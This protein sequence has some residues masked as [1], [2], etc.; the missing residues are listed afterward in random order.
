MNILIIGGGGREHAMAWKMARSPQLEKLFIAPGNAGTAMVGTNM[1]VSVDDF[2][3]IKELVLA[4]KIEMVVVGPEVPL[5]AGVVDFFME[6]PDLKMLNT[7]TEPDF[8]K[9]HY[10]ETPRYTRQTNEELRVQ[11]ANLFQ[12]DDERVE[13]IRQLHVGA[14]P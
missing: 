1:P 13:E 3:G 5:V 11:L 4:E 10:K 7:L 9:L 6:D 14:T 12:L 2:E 8:V